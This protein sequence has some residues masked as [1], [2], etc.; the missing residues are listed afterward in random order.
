MIDELNLTC[1]SLRDT[2]CSLKYEFIGTKGAIYHDDQGLI[3]R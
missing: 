2:R 1:I 3:S